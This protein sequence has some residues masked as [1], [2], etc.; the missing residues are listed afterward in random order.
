MITR[1]RVSMIAALMMTLG[2][3][4]VWGSV[5]AQQLSQEQLRMLQQL[6]PSEREALM[7]SM[8]ITPGQIPRNGQRQQD[9]SDQMQGDQQLPELIEPEEEP[10]EP[11]LEPDSSIVLTLRLP[12]DLDNQKLLASR[13]ALEEDRWL[14]DLEGSNTFQLDNAGILNLPGVA[15]I[16]LAGLTA[17]EAAKRIV[18][19]DGLGLFEAELTYLPLEKTGPAGLEPFGY[20]TFKG[21]TAVSF[22][23]PTDVPVPQD[24]VVGPG[25]VVSVQLFGNVNAQYEL[26]VT[27]DGTVNFPEIGPIAVAGL[28]FTEMKEVIEARIAEQMIGVRSS[29][30]MGELRSIRVFV[31]GDVNR[32]G[33]Y[34]I[35][36]LSTVTNALFVGGGVAEGGSLRNIQVK[37][38]GKTVRRIDGYQF[39]L[40]GDTSD[41]IRLQPGDVI[42]VPPVGPTVG[43]AGEVRRPAIYELLGDTTVA[44]ALDLAGGLTPIGYEGQ[45]RLERIASTEDRVILTLDLSDSEDRRLSVRDGDVIQVDPVLDRL[46][47]SIRLRGHVYRPGA[48]QWRPEM[49]LTDLIPGTDL[50]RPQADRH[51]LLI[52]REREAGGPIEIV[53]ADLSAALANRGGEENIDLQ[54]RDEIFVFDLETGRQKQIDPILEELRL[55]SR[56]GEPTQEVAISGQVRAPGKYPLEPDMTLGDLLRAGAYLKDS[57]YGLQA[58]LVRYTVGPDNRRQSE[59][60]QV[61]LAGVMAGDPVA[62]LQLEP[63]DVLNIKETPLWREQWAVEIRGEVNFPGEYAI[64]P[65]ETLLSVLNRAGGLTEFAFPQGSVFVREDLKERE[66]E[67]LNRLADRIESDLATIGLQAA[68]FEDANIG[69]SMSLGQSL[70]SQMRNA[71]PIGRLVIDLPSL[72]QYQD[73]AHDLVLKGGDMLVVPG[74]RQEVTVLGEVQY[75]TSHLFQ[76]GLDRDDYLSLS[77]GLTVNADK[78]RI[79]VVK[80]NGSVIAGN[81]G[82]KWFRRQANAGIEPGDTIV[83][84]LDV[85]RMPSLALWRTSTTILYNLAISVAAIGSL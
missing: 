9:T 73:A 7:R 62:N 6:S 71:E 42:F 3:A 34:T 53:S 57:A 26:P 45:A 51:Y 2:L 63:Y 1:S 81:G 84:P 35:S 44:D 80:A 38:G 49:R 43:V 69:Q 85:D 67:Q 5:Q 20:L 52:R 36:S 8:G 68:R 31:L 4:C 46:A 23:P 22:Q 14:A 27:R 76:P 17:E 55:Q 50:L 12:D 18:A 41:D 60:L 25:D 70:L 33:S 32:P 77:G 21:R 61:D 19:E 54:E 24:Y 37:R 48:Y 78:K 47:G 28:E 40:Q 11:R 15:S 79:Y 64:T 72:L 30:T 13:L 56:Y 83:V 82:S 74:Q 29:I 59:L 39:L 16:P 75:S 65:G 58:E 10:E 66:R